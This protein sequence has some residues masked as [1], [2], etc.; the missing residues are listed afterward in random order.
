M[1]FVDVWT[2]WTCDYFQVELHKMSSTQIL[3]G[4]T[5]LTLKYWSDTELTLLQTLKQ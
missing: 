5:F 3:D 1:F 4:D 2:E